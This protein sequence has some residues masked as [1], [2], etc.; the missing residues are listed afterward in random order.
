MSRSGSNSGGS[1]GSG[2]DQIINRAG[3]RERKISI[4]ITGQDGSKMLFS[5]PRHLKLRVLFLEYCQRKQLNYR[6]AR[7]LHE[8][9]RVLGRCTPA[10]LNLEDGAELNCMLHQL[11]GGFYTMPATT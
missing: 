3:G 8:S 10:E 11:G 4:L 9:V 5:T 6:T 2:G 7:F 1:S